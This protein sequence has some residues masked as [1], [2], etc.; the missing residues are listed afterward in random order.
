M[1]FTV[2]APGQTDYVVSQVLGLDDFEKVQ[3]WIRYAFS[4]IH[5]QDFVDEV[6][7]VGTVVTVTRT[8]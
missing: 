8:A 2:S 7:P 3:A 6:L 4:G 1:E 5:A